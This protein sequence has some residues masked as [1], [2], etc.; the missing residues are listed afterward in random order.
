MDNMNLGKDTAFNTNKFN[1]PD[2]QIQRVT[3]FDLGKADAD[4][5][6][7]KAQGHKW[8]SIDDG[9]LTIKGNLGKGA[10]CYVKE[11]ECQV[12]REIFNQKTGR[13]E[14]VMGK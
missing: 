5:E 10:F 1:Q 13:R 8:L 11:A 4:P 9:F 7:G 2:R 14:T 6:D 12:Y 3:N